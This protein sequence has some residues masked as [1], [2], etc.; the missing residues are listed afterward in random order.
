[1]PC[2]PPGDLPDPGIEPASL[3]SPALVGGFFFLPLVPPGKPRSWHIIFNE[4]L[5]EQMSWEA[6]WY[7]DESEL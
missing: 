5:E 1:M 7:S 6:V 2:S 3:K 4:I